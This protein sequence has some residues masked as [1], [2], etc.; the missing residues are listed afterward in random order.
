MSTIIS[1]PKK[2]KVA[3]LN[4]YRPVALTSVIMKCFERLVKDHIISSLPDTLDPLQF[5]YRPDRSTENTIAIAL[6][7]AFAHLDQRNAYVRMLLI[8]NSLAF[9]TIVHSELTT[10]FEALGLKSFLCEWILDFLMYRPQVVKV[11]NLIFSTL[12][13]NTG[14]PQGCILSPLLYSQYTHDCVV[15]HSFNSIIKFADDTTIV[16]ITNNDETADRGGR[17]AL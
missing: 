7:A 3:E 12:I 15:S 2:G 4:D 5:T 13:L 1:V 11:G 6:H 14:A 8:E 10:K 17:L 16:L 9:N